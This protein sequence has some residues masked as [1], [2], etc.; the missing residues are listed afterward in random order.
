MGPNSPSKP[1][2]IGSRWSFPSPLVDHR[3][4]RGCP[5]LTG[6]PL[7]LFAMRN[8]SLIALAV[9]LALA[10]ALLAQ[11]LLQVLAQLLIGNAAVAGVGR[12]VVLL[13]VL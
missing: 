9:A 7:W 3:K 1:H 8:G 2:R 13:L 11:Q 5:A 12:A 10:L 6:Q 4:K